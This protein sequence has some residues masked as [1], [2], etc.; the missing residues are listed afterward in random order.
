MPQ[1]EPRP[2]GQSCLGGRPQL[3]IPSLCGG[4]LL[5]VCMCLTVWGDGTVHRVWCNMVEEEG[6]FH[7]SGTGRGS[8]EAMQGVCW[9]EGA[10]EKLRGEQGK[11]VTD[12][13][14]LGFRVKIG[15]IFTQPVA[16][17]MLEVEVLGNQMG[18]A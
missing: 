10:G 5:R 13:E 9:L 14:D 17:F 11:V 7:N 3:G 2:Q 12:W 8:D 1:G 15:V 16:M 6:M 4:N 18:A